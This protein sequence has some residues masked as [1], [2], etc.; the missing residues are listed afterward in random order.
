VVHLLS[1]NRAYLPGST[2]DVPGALAYK[3]NPVCPSAPTLI[4]EALVG[5][6]PNNCV[7]GTKSVRVTA[8]AATTGSN[9]SDQFQAIYELCAHTFT[10]EK[11]KKDIQGEIRPR[12]EDHEDH[13]GGKEVVGGSLAS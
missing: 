13:D 7:P 6:N 1:I 8:T 4:T 3:K 9:C 12:Y 11:G 2:V 10:K 5:S